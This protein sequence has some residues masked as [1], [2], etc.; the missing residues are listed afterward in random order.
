M[1]QTPQ[2][3]AA[4]QQQHRVTPRCTDA[5]QPTA[6]LSLPRPH[7]QPVCD[8]LECAAQ[9]AGAVPLHPLEEQPLHPNVRTRAC[10]SERAR[11]EAA[12]ANGGAA[13]YV[14]RD[15]ACDAQLSSQRE[16]HVRLGLV[17]ELARSELVDVVRQRVHIVEH[18][19]TK[20]LALSEHHAYLPARARTSV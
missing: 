7:L 10:T 5:A 18:V 8:T 13:R 19:V 16:S 9:P 17:A 1:P 20:V 12:G 14:G 15:A 2:A 11:A 3:T 6:P 4:N